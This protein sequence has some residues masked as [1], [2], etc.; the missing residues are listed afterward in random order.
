MIHLLIVQLDIKHDTDCCTDHSPDWSVWIVSHI[1]LSEIFLFLIPPALSQHHFSN[2]NNHLTVSSP[3]NKML[4][5][6]ILKHRQKKSIVRLWRS[7]KLPV[8][9]KINKDIYTCRLHALTI[10]NNFYMFLVYTFSLA[11]T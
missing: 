1:F 7:Y 9:V 5:N 6:Y 2:L 4:F 11:W 10:W 3:S 8:C